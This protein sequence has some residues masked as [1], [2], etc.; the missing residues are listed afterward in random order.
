MV[1]VI[2][3]VFI[4]VGK[5]LHHHDLDNSIHRLGKLPPLPMGLFLED[6]GGSRRDVVG[7]SKTTQS[8]LVGIAT[9]EWEEL[10]DYRF[11]LA[12][13]IVADCQQHHVAID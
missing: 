9:V 11:D 7:H 10:P 5:H 6:V 4:V 1:F 8:E 3:I 2:I 13:H 12:A